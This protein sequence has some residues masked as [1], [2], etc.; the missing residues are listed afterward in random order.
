LEL[1]A[2]TCIFARFGV[3]LTAFSP[4]GVRVRLWMQSNDRGWLYSFV[5][6]SEA[7]NMPVVRVRARILGEAHRE[8]RKPTLPHPIAAAR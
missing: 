3:V 2:G 7:L 6:I 5:S 1:G 4:G 8:I